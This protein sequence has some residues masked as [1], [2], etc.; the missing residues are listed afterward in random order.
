MYSAE[1]IQS[2][3]GAVLQG[4]GRGDRD[5]CIRVGC[6]YPRRWLALYVA[7]GFVLVASTWQN[8]RSRDPSGI[9]SDS[10]CGEGAVQC[11]RVGFRARY[12]FLRLQHS[13]S[14]CSSSPDTK[15]DIAELTRGNA[16]WG[17]SA[18][19]EVVEEAGTT[20]IV[21]DIE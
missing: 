14:L 5:R 7:G 11:C 15:S 2:A 13:R 16:S 3:P 9:G 19:L 18:R 20:Y 10:S 8:R 1:S 21:P 12:E 6:R 4:M 17:R